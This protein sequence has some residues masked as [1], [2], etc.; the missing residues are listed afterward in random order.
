MD[1]N[2]IWMRNRVK[3][4]WDRPGLEYEHWEKVMCDARR[5]GH[6]RTVEQSFKHMN[7]FD[8]PVLLGE[9]RFVRL[10]TK[11]HDTVQTPNKI[12]LNMAWSKITTGVYTL[13]FNPKLLSI[14]K[15]DRILLDHVIQHEPMSVYA[16]AKSAG[17]NYRRVW[18]AV[19]RL[20]QKNLFRIVPYIR[21]GR[22]CNLVSA[23]GVNDL[24]AMIES[25]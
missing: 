10:W 24:D 15:M 3:A 5:R 23:Q 19:N 13:D 16:L 6:A 8:M 4:F 20:A 2:Q 7:P 17:R 25:L 21:N 14:H 22:K 12:L 1:C 18:D 11:Y 9:M